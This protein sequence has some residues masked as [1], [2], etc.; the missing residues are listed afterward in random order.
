MTN[1]HST[2][3]GWRA[4]F[5]TAALWT[6]LGAIPG[7]LDPAASFLRFHGA[8]ADSPLVLE[9]YRGAWGQTLLFA[10]GYAVAAIDPRRHGL[11]L[12]LGGI[13]KLLYAIR[14]LSTLG[15]LPTPMALVAAA[16]DLVFVALIAAFL[17]TTGTARSLLTPPE[18]ARA[19]RAPDVASRAE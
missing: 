7:Y 8:P 4:V 3:W 13:G 10:V 6:L 14:V 11:L 12:L 17:L 16:G 5:A 1:L 2:H 15:D 19:P 18:H 9:L